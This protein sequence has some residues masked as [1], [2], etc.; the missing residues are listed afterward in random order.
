MTTEVC[1]AVVGMRAK[2][3]DTSL[4]SIATRGRLPSPLLEFSDGC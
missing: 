1:G 3:G 2:K 4:V